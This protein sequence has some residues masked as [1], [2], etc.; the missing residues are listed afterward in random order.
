[1]KDFNKVAA[2]VKSGERIKEMRDH[3]E[4][5]FDVA[6][7][8]LSHQ[9]HLDLIKTAKPVPEEQRV[10]FNKLWGE[11][12]GTGNNI[13][14]R[15]VESLIVRQLAVRTSAKGNDMANPVRLVGESELRMGNSLFHGIKN[16]AAIA[17]AKGDRAALT[18][19]QL[20]TLIA[21]NNSKP[22]VVQQNEKAEISAQFEEIKKVLLGNDEYNN[23]RLQLGIPVPVADTR[24]AADWDIH[25]QTKSLKSWLIQ[26]IRTTDMSPMATSI[27]FRT[28][29]N[30]DIISV[31]KIYQLHLK[32]HPFPD[33]TV[34]YDLIKKFSNRQYEF[35]RVMRLRGEIMM[36]IF[37]INI[38][39]DWKYE[40]S[41]PLKQFHLVDCIPRVSPQDIIPGARFYEEQRNATSTLEALRELA[42]DAQ[43]QYM[44]LARFLRDFEEY[45]QEVVIKQGSVESV[46]YRNRNIQESY[47]EYTLDKSKTK[48]VKRIE[49]DERERAKWVKEE[50]KTREH[51]RIGH[52][53]HLADGRVVNVRGATINEGSP[54]G[55]VVKDYKLR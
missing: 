35:I 19:A 27:V 12:Y 50:P 22:I 15:E 29:E 40:Y 3:L 7:E 33:Y 34:A 25:D 18:Q 54:L 13:S 17:Y 21:L 6:V 46:K 1:M 10:S 49:A 5:Q 42:T 53:R 30:E 44:R 2:K 32:N 28:E 51:E 23:R 8:K 4:K 11:K 45:D 26:H 14:P 55:K 24:S 36:C 31:N 38:Y 37:S 39:G 41:V 47:I 52:K 43:K 16:E 20:D 9:E 48:L